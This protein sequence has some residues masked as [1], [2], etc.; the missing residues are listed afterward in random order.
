MQVVVK[1]EESSIEGVP[2]GDKLKSFSLVPLWSCGSPSGDCSPQRQ[3]RL[4]TYWKCRFSSVPQTCQLE[5][6]SGAQQSVQTSPPG[7]GDAW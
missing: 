6:G 5:M 4:G 1:S 2:A 3:P 7:H